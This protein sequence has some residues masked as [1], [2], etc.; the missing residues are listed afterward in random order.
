MSLNEF[1]EST[2][3][4]ARAI[5]S[6]ESK[7]GRED[8]HEVRRLQVPVGHLHLSGGGYVA[9]SDGFPRFPKGC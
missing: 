9:A 1:H 8:H 5:I 2:F 4:L 6:P 7:R 3:D